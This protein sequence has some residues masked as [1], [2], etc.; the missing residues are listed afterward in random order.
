MSEVRK[1]VTVLMNTAFHLEL[2]PNT[3]ERKDYSRLFDS[4]M[5]KAEKQKVLFEYIYESVKRNMFELKAIAFQKQE[6]LRLISLTC[7]SQEF[8][9]DFNHYLQCL[10]Y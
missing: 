3:Q 5:E 8:S 1:E 4:L 10:D 2:W 6:Y 7:I 9:N